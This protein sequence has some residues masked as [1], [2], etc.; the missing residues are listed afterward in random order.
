MSQTA[1]ARQLQRLK[2]RRALLDAALTLLEEQ[3]LGSLGLREV[4]RAAGVAPTAFY[5]HFRDIEDLGIALVDEALENL[6]ATVRSTLATSGDAEQRMATA[7]ELMATL[8]RSYPAHIR[9]IVRER[10]GGVRR[11]REAVTGQL[12]AFAVEVAE[13]L[14]SDPLGAGWSRDDLLMLARLYVDHMV[15]TASAFLAAALEDNEWDAV[16]RTA[17]RQLR[18]I[19]AGRVHWAPAGPAA[20]RDGVPDGVPDEGA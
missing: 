16:S 13:S 19:H 2:T 1:G 18:L 10:H 15:M 7:V 17:L 8:V 12:D 3:S 5:R 9:F 4:T 11:V 20:A 14:G 6:H